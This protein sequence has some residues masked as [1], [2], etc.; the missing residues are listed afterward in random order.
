MC[1]SA[2]MHVGVCGFVCVWWCGMW[3]VYMCVHLDGVTVCLDVCVRMC[4][5]ECVCACVLV[6][7]I[8]WGQSSL[9]C[10]FSCSPTPL[11]SPWRC[12]LTSL[13]RPGLGPPWRCCLTWPYRNNGH[14]CLRQVW[15]L[16][17][18]SQ[19]YPQRAFFLF[20]SQNIYIFFCTWWNFLHVPRCSAFCDVCV[21]V[22][23]FV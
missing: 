16:F 6:N 13:Q 23:V 10:V 2:W 18:H 8:L 20:F 19:K 3:H 7:G 9:C 12:C 17:I 15:F 4:V 21:C 1:V 5:C 22:C 11:C 14:I